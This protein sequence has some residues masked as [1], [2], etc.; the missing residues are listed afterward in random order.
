MSPEIHRS[1]SLAEISAMA[2]RYIC[3]TARN[4]AKDNGSFSLALAGGNTPR[5]LYKILASRPA[6]EDMP[7]EHTHLFWGDERWVPHDHPDSNFGMAKKIL[8]EKLPV[9]AGNV[10]PI[11]TGLGSPGA[12]AAA[13]EKLLRDIGAAEGLDLILLGMGNDG[14]TASLFPESPALNIT[15]RL[16]TDVLA[17]AHVPIVNRVTLTLPAIN[18][19]RDVLFL[20][21]GPRKKQILQTILDDPATAFELYPAAR[22]R[23]KNKSIWFVAQNNSL[24]T[25]VRKSLSLS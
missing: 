21:A 17:P 3:R 23:P 14:H 10:H 19:A 9:P 6:V 12:G 25:K 20:I 7:W 1:P 2:A 24:Q 22:V 16:V 4:K 8:L 18:M 11:P 5:L 13:Y 15:D